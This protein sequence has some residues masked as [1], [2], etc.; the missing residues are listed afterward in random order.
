MPSVTSFSLFS[1]SLFSNLFYSFT[2][3]ISLLI[4]IY[5]ISHK[6]YLLF[7]FFIKAIFT[8]ERALRFIRFRI[9]RFQQMFFRFIMTQLSL[10][11]M[12]GLVYILIKLN[13]V[14]EP[15]TEDIKSSA[16]GYSYHGF[17]YP[18]VSYVFHLMNTIDTT[19]LR[20]S[21]KSHNSHYPV[22]RTARS[23]D[24][25]VRTNIN[26]FISIEWAVWSARWNVIQGTYF[27]LHLLQTSSLW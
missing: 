16:D 25:P 7:L 3:D 20:G 1:Y 2:I 4:L 17:K 5:V 22:E 19:N 26:G 24:W 13:R 27:K 23:T 21:I 15:L 14:I 6:T 9:S 12:A 8:T 10:G 11:A 18:T